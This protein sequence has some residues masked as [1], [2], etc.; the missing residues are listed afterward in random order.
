MRN[1]YYMYISQVIWVPWLVIKGFIFR[2]M[3][4]LTL[5][6]LSSLIQCSRDVIHIDL[7]TMFSQS[8]L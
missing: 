2:D 8:V 5:W 3:D 1:I 6:C 4:R 7:L